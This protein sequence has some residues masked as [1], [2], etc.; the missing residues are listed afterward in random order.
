MGLDGDFVAVGFDDDAGLGGDEGV[1]RDAFATDDGFKEEGVLAP[2]A[3]GEAF[4]GGDGGE[5][6]GQ[7]RAIDGESEVAVGRG[8]SGGDKGLELVE[9]RDVDGR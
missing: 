6:I 9:G 5:V 1:A 4:E 2:P 7:E 3:F 8:V